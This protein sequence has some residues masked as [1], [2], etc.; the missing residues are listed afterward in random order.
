MA[1]WAEDK[2][3]LRRN[4]EA[5]RQVAGAVIGGIELAMGGRGE[6]PLEAAA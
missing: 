1:R 3:V 4:L 6:Q 5:I 2:A